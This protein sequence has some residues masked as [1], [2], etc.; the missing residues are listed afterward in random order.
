MSI[1]LKNTSYLD[2]R[3]EKIIE[4]VDIYIENNLIKKIGTDLSFSNCEIIN[5]ENKLAVPAYTNS[6]SHLGMSMLRNYGDDLD[7]NTWLTKKIWPVEDKMTPDDIYWSSMLSIVEN[8]KSGVSTVCDMYYSLDR[9]SEGII[10]SGI[11]GVLTR[12]LMDI[13]G[14]GDS[15]LE[16]LKELY[17][18]YNNAGNGRVKILPGP[19]AIYTCSK[20]YLK[21]ILKLTQKFDG[22]LNIHLSETEKEV[23]DCLNIHGTTPAKYL[24]SIGFFDVKVIAAHCTHL[25]YD[26][27]EMISKYAVYP[28]YN[29]S[30]NLKLA[31][32]FAPI[33]KMIDNN[34]IVGI[35]TDGSSSNNNQDI[36]EEMHLASLVNKAVN[37]DAVSVKA[38]DVIKMATING[39][40]IMGYNGGLIDEGYLADITLFNLESLGFTPKN[41]LISALCYS[42]NSHYVS[43]LIVDGKI[44]MQDRNILTIDEEKIKYMVSKLAEKLFKR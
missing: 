36:I 42:A 9:V 15:R 7:L 31:S 24:E 11:R 44:I 3:N 17:S 38:I 1:L 26:E 40:Q 4:N 33:Q 30:S 25:S 6:H 35:G 20:E 16:E 39:A 29:P 43:D 23:R 2:I 34:L 14:G 8:I 37:R 21:K 19:H 5:C 18:N 22:V 13:T 27:I 12:G 32:G 10:D 28:I 41:N